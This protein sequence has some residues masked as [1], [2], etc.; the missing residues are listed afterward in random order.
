MET[1]AAEIINGTVNQIIV[2][3]ALWAT[4]KLGGFW[5]DT[6]ILV[7]IGWTWNEEDG[8]LPPQLES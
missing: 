2:G 8:F 1:Y 6:D 3:E 7:G 4:Q 5:V